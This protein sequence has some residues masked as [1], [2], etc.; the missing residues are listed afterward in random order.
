MTYNRTPL[1]Y[2][3]KDWDMKCSVFKK[4]SERKLS[5]ISRQDK[6]SST[7]KHEASKITKRILNSK[8]GMQFSKK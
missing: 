5:F 4:G 3:T 7:L 2:E 8:R 6:L 1:W